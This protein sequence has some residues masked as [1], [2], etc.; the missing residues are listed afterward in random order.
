MFQRILVIIMENIQKKVISFKRKIKNI[1]GSNYILIPAKQ[2][3]YEDITEETI[4]DVTLE[5]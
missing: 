3:E 1:G 2:T 5:Y 4:F